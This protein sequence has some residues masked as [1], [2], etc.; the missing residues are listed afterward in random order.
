MQS[1][2]K[3]K[4]VLVSLALLPIIISLVIFIFISSRSPSSSPTEYLD[5]GS[6][7]TVSA[8]KN[9]TPEKFGAETQG[10]LFLG[11]SKLIDSGLTAEQL[12]L[13]KTIMSRFSVT[14]SRYITE[15]S[16]SVKTTDQDISDDGINLTFD[17][18]ANR[19]D[20]YLCTI[21]YSG[22]SEVRV[23]IKDKDAKQ[24]FDSSVE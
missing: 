19:T 16:V 15:L 24:V 2:N 20:K 21:S 18:T 3:N 11:F 22:L 4:I 13:T 8:P 14:G 23:V 17:L 6:G 12:E 10:P 1:P 9:K 7:E 5:P